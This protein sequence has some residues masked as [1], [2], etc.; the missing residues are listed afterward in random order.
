MIQTKYAG[1]KKVDVQIGGFTVHTDLPASMKGYLYALISDDKEKIKIG[2]SNTHHRRIP[3]L[4]SGTPFSFDVMKVVE[5]DDGLKI[6]MMEK[7]FHGKYER[8]SLPKFDGYTEWLIA[9]DE[10]ISEIEEM[11]R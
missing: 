11:G 3:V 6:R 1:N 4:R 10:L 8:A 2:I 5:D 7:Y 9:T